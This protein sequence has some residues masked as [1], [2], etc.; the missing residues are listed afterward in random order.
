MARTPQGAPPT[1]EPD[2]KPAEDLSR[3][4]DL[5][6]SI[7]VD[8]IAQSKGNKLGLHPQQP[9]FSPKQHNGEE[10]LEILQK[11]GRWTSLSGLSERGADSAVCH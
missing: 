5:L 4:D 6:N 11:V 9:G 10:V 1:R 7:L 8:Q 2:T 3:D